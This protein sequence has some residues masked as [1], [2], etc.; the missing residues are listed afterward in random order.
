MQKF[1]TAEDGTPTQPVPANPM[2]HTAEITFVA[3][4]IPGRSGIPLDIA[5]LKNFRTEIQ[6]GTRHIVLT[7]CE[8]TAFENSYEAGGPV[9]CKLEIK[10]IS[11][12][13]TMENL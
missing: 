1:P 5:T 4:D 12:S 11:R 7:G 13:C 2:E 3:L 10:A 9:I 6:N 8:F